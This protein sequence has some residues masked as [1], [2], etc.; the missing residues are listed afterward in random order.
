M[1]PSQ[2]S[3]DINQ[4]GWPFDPWVRV[5]TLRVF[6]LLSYF[7]FCI[8]FSFCV[9]HNSLQ[10]TCFENHFLQCLFNLSQTLTKKKHTLM[11]IFSM[12]FHLCFTFQRLEL[13][14]A[15]SYYCA[16]QSSSKQPLSVLMS[17]SLH[18]YKLIH[19][20]RECA[21]GAKN[22]T[23]SA[24]VDHSQHELSDMTGCWK[25]RAVLVKAALSYCT[26]PA[27]Q[28]QA[29][30]VRCGPTCFTQLSISADLSHTHAHYTHSIIIYI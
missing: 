10:Y 1:Q 4:Q 6:S 11:C 19:V 29:D 5:R 20:C 18:T 25:T 17:R 30:L 8:T 14:K 28:T 16:I 7:S 21:W 2:Y 22:K 23:T 9:L 15:L 3:W 27:L 26:S 12:L 13:V 24:A